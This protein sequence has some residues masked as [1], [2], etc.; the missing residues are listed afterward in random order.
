MK[1]YFIGI[2]G[3]GLS[4]LALILKS[5]GHDVEGC[6]TP[7]YIFTEDKLKEQH[8]PIDS[9]DNF[10][11]YT[12]DYV[13]IGNT[14]YKKYEY[15]KE[16][17]PILTYQECLQKFAKQYHSIAVC[18]THGKTTTTC[19]L[20]QCFQKNFP[21]CYLI[22]DGSGYSDKNASYF[23]FE[24]CE[25]M[26]H[27]LQYQPNSILLTNIDYDHVDYFKTKEHY[28]QSFQQFCSQTSDFIFLSDEIDIQFPT[29]AKIYTYGLKK[30]SDLS[31]FHVQYLEKGISF[32]F[33]FQNKVYSDIFLPLYGK[34]MLYH[35]LGVFLCGLVYQ[36]PFE[37][38]DETLKQFQ[39]A[40]RRLNITLLN[41][42]N[43]IVD[44]YGHHPNEIK[45][46]LESIKQHYPTKK[47]II[48]FQP[49]RFS[50]VFTFFKE[51]KQIL[52]EVEKSYIL[53]FLHM[54][55]DEKKLIEKFAENGIFLYHDENINV[56][57][58]NTIFFFTGSKDMS[59][60]I[61]YLQ[62]LFSKSS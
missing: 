15:L 13:I 29:K 41:Q 49:D 2:K 19:M 51:F 12:C 39:P 31:A 24:A 38:M 37:N 44:D 40:S 30:T 59:C 11:I 18:G 21:L 8:I 6:D 35:A 22:G 56:E 48:I 46:T 43:L 60:H 53:P 14:F 42:E 36:I 26:D 33:R 1:F 20:S 27:F 23:I 52:K 62:S 54:D 32:S 17:F 61:H 57:T 25:Y 58:T 9:M 4:S 47:I 5:L 7:H 55:D 16:K 10:H 28:L 45:A 34:H 3:S 50:R